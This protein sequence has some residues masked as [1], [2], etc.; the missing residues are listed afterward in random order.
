M[1]RLNEMDKFHLKEI[2]LNSITDSLSDIEGFLN[3]YN[4]HP[5]VEGIE[6]N[7]TNIKISQGLVEK[8]FDEEIKLVAGQTRIIERGEAKVNEYGPDY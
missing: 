8:L 3:S 7:L 4:V 6:W 2:L 1:D 5:I